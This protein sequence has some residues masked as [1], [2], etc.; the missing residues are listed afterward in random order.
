L[1]SFPYRSIVV[2]SEDDP[3]GNPEYAK[4]RADAWGGE[5]VNIGRAGHINSAS[6][7][8]IWTQGLQLLN[9]LR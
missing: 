1:L 7:L 8:G 3:Y 6:N 4:S 9:G 5:F 2:C